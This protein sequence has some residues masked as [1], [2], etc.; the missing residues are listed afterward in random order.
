VLA[1]SIADLIVDGAPVVGAAAAALGAAAGVVGEARGG[2]LVAVSLEGLVGLGGVVRLERR[3]GLG[4]CGEK[5]T[6]TEE[7]GG[8]ETSA[9]ES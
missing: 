7:V 3:H 9:K 4:S 8:E 1:H 2:L 5:R 6:S